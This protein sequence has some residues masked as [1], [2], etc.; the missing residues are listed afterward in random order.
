VKA[1]LMDQVRRDRVQSTAAGRAN[2]PMQDH[3]TPAPAA[4]APVRTHP[5]A[6]DVPPAWLAELR[7]QVGGTLLWPALAGAT[8]IALLLLG[9]YTGW[10]GLQSRSLSQQLETLQQEAIELRAE[11]DQ[12]QGVH[13]ELQ[14]QLR[15][16][17][18][19]LALFVDATQVVA[20]E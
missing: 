5:A 8:V 7:R 10:L 14:Q 15:E 9:L 3:W 1:Q 18:G 13:E 11:N 6:E 2:H 19:Q 17:E 4:D 16:Q 12:L 20:L